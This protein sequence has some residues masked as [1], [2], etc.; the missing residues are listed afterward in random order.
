MIMV[1][2]VIVFVDK[3]GIAGTR[4]EI[5]KHLK[6]PQVIR[7]MRMSTINTQKLSVLI[8]H[9]LSTYLNPQG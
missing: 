4:K 3:V 6:E 9:I 5:R 1:V 7:T 8:T 2:V